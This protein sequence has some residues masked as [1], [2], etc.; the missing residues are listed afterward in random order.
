MKVGFLV[1]YIWGKGISR[2]YKVI[3][4]HSCKKSVFLIWIKGNNYIELLKENFKK[5]YN[6]VWKATKDQRNMGG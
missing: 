1:E 3:H 6:R 5:K 2:D 4:G